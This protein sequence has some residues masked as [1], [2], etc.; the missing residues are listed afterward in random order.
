MSKKQA[1]RTGTVELPFQPLDF[2]S[3]FATIKLV[4]PIDKS[5]LDG[6]LAMRL[7]P[8]FTPVATH[9]LAWFFDAATETARFANLLGRGLHKGRSR[10]P[11]PAD[12]RSGSLYGTTWRSCAPHNRTMSLRLAAHGG[13]V[14]IR[15]YESHNWREIKPEQRQSIFRLPL[16]QPVSV[17]RSNESAMRRQ[18]GIDSIDD[19]Q[20]AP[21]LAFHESGSIVKPGR[22]D[23][24]PLRNTRFREWASAPG[25]R[26]D[27]NAAWPP[28][29]LEHGHQHGEGHDQ[30]RRRP[31]N[32]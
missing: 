26:I 8:W 5:A 20:K 23:L 12:C 22:I 14:K 13:P 21:L 18:Y 6:P 16:D 24:A 28:R 27:A 10:R 29:G 17:A 32:Q 4:I 1:V 3:S 31:Y 15:R 2:G 19:E 9:F 11:V 7:P 30:A 25:L